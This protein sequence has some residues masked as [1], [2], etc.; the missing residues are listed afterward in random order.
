[1]TDLHALRHISTKLS[2]RTWFGNLLLLLYYSRSIFYF[3]IFF[4]EYLSVELQACHSHPVTCTFSTLDSFL[5][6]ET[7][8][9]NQQHEQQT[10]AQ[11]KF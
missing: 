4:K 3:H 1:M 9:T 2:K 11:R 7:S 10:A 8:C 6:K 5:L